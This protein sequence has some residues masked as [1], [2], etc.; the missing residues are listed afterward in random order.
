MPGL[1]GSYPSS[2]ARRSFSSAR[3]SMRDTLRRA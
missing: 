2:I 3:F 1:T